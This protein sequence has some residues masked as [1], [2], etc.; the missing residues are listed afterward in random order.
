MVIAPQCLYEFWV[1]T[2]RPVK[3]NG[4]GYSPQRAASWL[5]HLKGLGLLLPENDGVYQRW[6]TL[7]K[8]HDVKGKKGHDAH[9]AAWMQVHGVQSILTFNAGDFSRFGIQ[10]VDP[11]LLPKP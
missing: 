11:R 3:D 10:M 2:T 8:D 5:R 1:V 9:L 4:L 6:E 7:V